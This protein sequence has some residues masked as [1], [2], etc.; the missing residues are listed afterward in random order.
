[1]NLSSTLV[2]ILESNKEIK[3]IATQSGSVYPDYYS[4][5]RRAEG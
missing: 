2:S 5:A 3:L 1:M 4:I